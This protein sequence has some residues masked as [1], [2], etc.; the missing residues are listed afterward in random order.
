MPKVTIRELSARLQSAADEELRLR[1]TVERLQLAVREQAE[2]LRTAGQTPLASS[3]AAARSLE[4]H[5]PICF[6]ALSD[7]DPTLACSHEICHA[8]CIKLFK[9][10]SSCPICRKKATPKEL[11][12]FRRPQ[13]ARYW[14]CLRGSDWPGLGDVIAVVL[15]TRTLGGR[16]IETNEDKKTLSMVYHAAEYEI[17]LDSV[18]EI[19]T[20]QYLLDNL[21]PREDGMKRQL[22][23]VA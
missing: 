23:N 10:A 15:R 16:H 11:F 1:A 8:C 6:E 17:S 5:C 2:R 20:L 22:F 13:L 3:I 21:P 7:L 18:Q 12:R 9:D 4:Y 19:F 14:Q